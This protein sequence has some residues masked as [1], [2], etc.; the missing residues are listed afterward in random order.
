MRTSFAFAFVA[1]AAC[2]GAQSTGTQSPGSGSGSGSGGSAQAG[3][4]GDDMLEI[5]VEIQSV[6]LEPEALRRPGVPKG[7]PEGQKTPP[8]RAKLD[9]HITK[10]RDALAKQK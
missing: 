6:L 4:P 7:D 2:G 5:P 3:A 8:T 1:L 9:L 10:Q